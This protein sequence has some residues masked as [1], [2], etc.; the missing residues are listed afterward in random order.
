MAITGSTVHRR[1]QLSLRDGFEPG[2][3]MNTPD[4]HADW[5]DALE[6][7]RL[8]PGEADALHRRL[9]GRPREQA[10]LAEE[11]ALD[12]A[13]DVLPA[14][15]V[16]GN[17]ASRV[18]AEIDRDEADRKRRSRGWPAWLG[19]F[20]IIGPAASFAA[21]AVAMSGWWQFQAHQRGQLATNVAEV[22]QV[23][24][25]VDTLRDFEAI[26]ALEATPLPGDVELVAALAQ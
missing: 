14:P 16:P 6:G 20:R 26:R 22:A 9:A 2:S 24:P 5:L 25:D 12:A 18:W 10:R 3:R 19:G 15:P 11:L 4:P 21:L 7:R 1:P 23:F 13:L 17:F 8:T